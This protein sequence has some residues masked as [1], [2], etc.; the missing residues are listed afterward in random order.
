MDVVLFRHDPGGASDFSALA[1]GPLSSTSDDCTGRDGIA[2]FRVARCVFV[3]YAPEPDTQVPFSGWGQVRQV[4]SDVA[5]AVDSGNS[6]HV[7]VAW[8]DDAASTGPTLHLQESRDGGLS[9]RDSDVETVSQ[10]VN[11]SLAVNSR[12]RLAFSYQRVDGGMEGAWVTEVKVFEDADPPFVLHTYVLAQPK[13]KDLRWCDQPYL[14][15]YMRLLAV[16]NHFFGVFSASGNVATSAYF[17]QGIN[18]ERTIP[19]AA[20]ANCAANP[21]SP[22]LSIDPYFF[23]VEQR[24]FGG[25]WVTA[26]ALSLYKVAQKAIKTVKTTFT[27]A[28]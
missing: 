20:D 3:P 7:F 16:G 26:T 2:G 13:V 22:E 15:E 19:V 14:G 12:G 10:A 25:K 4:F 23:A 27:K 5:L 18:Y 11:P 1:D 24:W 21:A 28:R 8:G 6:R 17:P 9:W